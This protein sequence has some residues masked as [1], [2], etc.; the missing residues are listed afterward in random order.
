MPPV[1][2]V[3]AGPKGVPNGGVNVGQSIRSVK[4]PCGSQGWARP[5]KNPFWQSRRKQKSSAAAPAWPKSCVQPATT[6]NVV[7]PP[8]VRIRA[9]ST[10]RRLDLPDIGL[11]LLSPVPTAA[12]FGP[13]RRHRPQLDSGPTASI[14][15]GPS[16]GNPLRPIERIHTAVSAGPTLT[17][18]SPTLGKHT[19]AGAHNPIIGQTACQVRRRWRKR[20]KSL[21]PRWTRRRQS[22]E[23]AA[24]PRA[25]AGPRIGQG[26]GRADRPSVAERA[27]QTAGPVPMRHAS[28]SRDTAQSLQDKKE[29]DSHLSATVRSWIYGSSLEA[30]RSINPHAGSGEPSLLCHSA[31]S[32]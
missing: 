26:P 12:T 21:A 8:S 2:V 27:A 22:I 32:L 6:W 9:I 28:D 4:P 11:N 3:G 24:W 15:T 23:Q 17:D 1:A 19:A 10:L 14:P 29:A 5:P 18:R 25:R 7:P 13:R 20:W 16:L 30:A 31:R